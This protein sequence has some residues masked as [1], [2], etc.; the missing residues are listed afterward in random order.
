VVLAAT[1]VVAL[2]VLAMPASASSRA[3]AASSS[4]I[5]FDT[6]YSPNES[7]IYT[8]RPDGSDRHRLTNSSRHGAWDPAFSPDGSHIAFARDGRFGSVLAVME[9]DGAGKY[10]LREDSG[11]D[12]YAPA[13]TPD[14]LGIVFVRCHQAPGYPCRIAR[15]DLSGTHLVELTSGSWH[16]GTGPFGS[17]PGEL[18][19]AV[20]P[21]DGSVA[22]SSDR[23]G[24]DTRL[25]V[26]AA[27]GGDLHAIS[28]PAITAGDP[29][30]SPD[31]DWISV[32]GDP[33]F[34]ATFLLH[35]DGSGLHSV[36]PGALFASFSPSGQRLVGLQES[37]G[38][39]ATFSVGGGPMTTVPRTAGG[40]FSDWSYV[41]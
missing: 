33:Q 14:G 34:G 30:W 35:P 5:A 6:R 22:F 21:V 18:G 17:F 41:P 29:S 8:I 39:L 37:S 7:Q 9:T 23:G 12:D 10:L 32:T 38:K 27:D 28:R 4:L 24:Y 31:G 16:D 26:M 15:M 19:P 3:T 13:W 11:Y 2:I 1:F 36:E 25:F 40:T 20:S